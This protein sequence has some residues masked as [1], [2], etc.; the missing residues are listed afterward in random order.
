MIYD[1][2]IRLY[3]VAIISK[4]KQY[5]KIRT[6]KQSDKKIGCRWS[7]VDKMAYMIDPA[8]LRHLK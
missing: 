4:S 7:A 5:K 8:F 6:T 3:D 2:Y 1:G